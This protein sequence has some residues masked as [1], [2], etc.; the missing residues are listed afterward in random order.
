M[1]GPEA[2]ALGAWDQA[3]AAAFETTLAA[4]ESA[5]ALEGL[6]PGPSPK[7]CGCPTK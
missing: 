5:E 7:G 1:T 4:G 3:R 6:G 2:L